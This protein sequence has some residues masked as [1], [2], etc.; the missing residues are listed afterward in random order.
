MID[1]LRPLEIGDVIAHEID[2]ARSAEIHARCVRGEIRHLLVIERAPTGLVLFAIALVVLL[3]VDLG[4]V[5]KACFAEVIGVFLRRATFRSV[6]HRAV[7]TASVF[8]VAFGES[9]AFS[10]FCRTSSGSDSNH[11]SVAQATALVRGS[12]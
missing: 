4:D 10:L 1:A 7:E 12:I 3:D 11:E 9:H 6:D 5:R 2:R 8:L